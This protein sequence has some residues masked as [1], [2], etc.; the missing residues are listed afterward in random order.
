LTPN[1]G[2]FWYLFIEILKNY[3]ATF[4]F[5]FHT[6][7]FFLPIPLALTFRYPLIKV[8]F[9]LL[10]ER[11]SRKAPFLNLQLVLIFAR[12]LKPY[13]TLSDVALSLTF[14]PTIA[15]L[16]PYLPHSVAM[17]ATFL[18]SFFAFPINYYWWIYQGSGN[19]NFYYATTLISNISQ[20]IL[21]LFMVR[22]QL[23]KDVC[24]QNPNIDPNKVIRE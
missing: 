7:P 2:I 12:I 15:Y 14:L 22:A 9:F 11:F 16:I 24:A 13:P 21:A 8:Y 4:L 18:F 1:T 3:P 20:G 10:A 23:L 5:V 19:A 17:S 6:L